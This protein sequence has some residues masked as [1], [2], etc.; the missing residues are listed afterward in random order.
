MADVTREQALEAALRKIRAMEI[1]ETL[2]II[3]AALAMPP[4]QGV[5]VA[6]H[7]EANNTA[8]SKAFWRWLPL[9]Y[10]D[11]DIG[12]ER[13]FTKYNM[14]VAFLAGWQHALTPPAPAPWTPPEDRPDGYRCRIAVDA[15]WTGT[16]WTT[17][18]EFIFDEGVYA[19]APAPEASHDR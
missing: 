15:M 19:F 14:E 11:G 10:R 12:D 6:K 3:D 13:K 2:D 9:A 7:P 16:A 8:Y 18:N 1:V 17:L 4:A 5:D